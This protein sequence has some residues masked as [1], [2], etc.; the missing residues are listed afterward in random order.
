MSAAA[1]AK[2]SPLPDDVSPEM[3]EKVRAL[4]MENRGKSGALIPVLQDAQEIV[5]YLPVALLERIAQ[6]LGVPGHEVFGVATFY[7]FFSMTPRGKNLI[8][9]C[10]GTACHLKGGA[11]MV[12]ELSRRLELAPGQTSADRRFTL[13]TV[14]CVG[15]CALAPVVVINNQYYPKMTQ[16]RLSGIIDQLLES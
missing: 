9:V 2:L 12:E 14:N 1:K 6:W 11:S 10:L 8:R 16:S 4:C 13:E 3:V 5:G 7:A 15:A